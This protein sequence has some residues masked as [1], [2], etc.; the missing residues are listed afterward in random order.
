MSR[1]EELQGWRW[2]KEVCTSVKESVRG[3]KGSLLT[4]LER[5]LVEKPEGYKVGVMKMI[6]IV[7]SVPD[8]S[9]GQIEPDE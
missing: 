3:W 4:T 5:G 9:V 8:T 2:A 7:R 1:V 6:E